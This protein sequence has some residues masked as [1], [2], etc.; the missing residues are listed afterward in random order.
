MIRCARTL[1]RA[2]ALAALAAAAWLPAAAPA[3]AA[4]GRCADSPHYQVRHWSRTAPV[5]DLDVNVM[6]CPWTTPDQWT[7]QALPHDA[8]SN[9]LT[10]HH[11][12]AWVLNGDTTP[13]YRTVT[14]EVHL[15]RC[16]PIDCFPDISSWRVV[17]FLG[18]DGVYVTRTE[19]VQDSC[20][21][22]SCDYQLAVEK[23]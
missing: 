5:A 2:L 21:H 14:V 10:T 22:P 12:R 20:G 16:G 19:T 17:Y 13:T 23:A 3:H 15:D 7:V 6:A 9:D 1:G 4:G 8:P 18:N 11:L